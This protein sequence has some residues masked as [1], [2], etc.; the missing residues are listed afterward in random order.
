MRPCRED[1]QGM[2]AQ[3]GRNYAFFDAP[4]GLF[5]S[6]DRTM[7]PPQWSD[8]GMFV[9][10]VMLLARGEGLHTCGIE[11]WTHWH[12][13][14]SAFIGLPDEHMLFCGMALGHADPAA[15]INAWR[16]PR[17]GVDGFA[18]FSGFAEL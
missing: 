16:A 10:T 7:G 18:A 13:T 8:L 11:A 12:K 5:F 15:P 2:H 14:V 17:D 4:V 6:I 9:Q 3:H 1:K